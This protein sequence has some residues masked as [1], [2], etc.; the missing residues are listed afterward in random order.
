[1][2]LRSFIALACTSVV[3]LTGCAPTSAP[4]AEPQ[5]STI[6]TSPVTPSPSSSHTTTAAPGLRLGSVSNFRDVAGTGAGL[7]IADGGHMTRGVVFRSGK[8]QGLSS[9]DKKAL[10]KAGITDIFDLRTVKVAERSPDPAVGDAKYHLI[11]IF[12][13]Y[14]TNDPMPTTV[15]AATRERQQLNRDFVTDPKQ[16]QRIGTLLRGIADAKG[17]VIIH[18]TEGKDRTGWASAILQLIAGADERTV[19]DDYL[20]SNKRRA[21]IIEQGVAKARKS[22]RTAADIARVRLTVADSYLSAGLDEMTRRYSDLDGYLTTGLGLD[23]KTLE[24]LR[25]KLQTA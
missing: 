7:A 3:L 24:R 21:D 15:S 1:M 2:D 25:S 16:R 18:C 17:A 10:I 13:V 9:T 6:A 8:L 19:L 23:Q 12:A 14:A 11:N 22:G 5:Q 4:V 20:L